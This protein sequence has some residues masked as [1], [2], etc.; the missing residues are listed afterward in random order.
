MVSPFIGGRPALSMR[1]MALPNWT[2]KLRFE[3]QSLLQLNFRRKHNIAHVLTRRDSA[4]NVP[5][6]PYG[7]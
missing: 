3:K 1:S 6:K 2:L 4:T 7:F 5:E